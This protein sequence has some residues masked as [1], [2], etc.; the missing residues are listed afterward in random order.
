MEACSK[1]ESL[2]GE[3]VEVH[4]HDAGLSTTSSAYHM[5]PHINPSRNEL[6]RTDLMEMI[7]ENNRHMLETT[8]RI[9]HESSRINQMLIQEY[10]LRL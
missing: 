6:T 4:I 5:P 2:D 7:Q 8:N 1:L 10:S 9:L 3:V